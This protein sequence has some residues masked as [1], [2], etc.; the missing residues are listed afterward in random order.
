[1]LP[2][3]GWATLTATNMLGVNVEPA[4]DELEA[5]LLRLFPPA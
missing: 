3:L 1:V 4:G 2:G 5:S